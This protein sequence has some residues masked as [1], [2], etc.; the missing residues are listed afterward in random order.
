LVE[1]VQR[2]LMSRGYERGPVMVDRRPSS[3]SGI[4]VRAFQDLVREA[5]GDQ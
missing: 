5:L 2:G 1:A 4:G 3:L